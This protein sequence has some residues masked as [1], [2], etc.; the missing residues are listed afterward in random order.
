MRTAALFCFVSLLAALSSAS[1]TSDFLKSLKSQASEKEF[2]QALES[3]PDEVYSDPQ[4]DDAISDAADRSDWKAARESLVGLLQGRVEF[5]SKPEHG[6]VKSPKQGAAE[7]LSQ[8]VYRDPGKGQG[9]NWLSR[10][11]DRISDWL[12]E[13]FKPP[14]PNAQFNGGVPGA[15]LDFLVPVMWTLLT[16]GLI[17]ALVLVAI[18]FKLVGFK[19]QAKALLEEDEELLTSDEWLAKAADLESSGQHREA[20]RCLF[21]A[22]LVRLD[23]AGVLKFVRSETNWEHLARFEAIKERPEGLDL[24]PI[25]REFDRVWY[26]HRVRGSED[27]VLFRDFYQSLLKLMRRMGRT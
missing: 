25:T 5:E 26:G 16:L 22:S 20:V 15:K 17:V 9:R 3:A 10:A 8:P 12:N 13:R 24:R 27:I 19:R 21:I 18:R 11:F 4:I 14:R 7:I 6:H 23:E 2:H 1:P